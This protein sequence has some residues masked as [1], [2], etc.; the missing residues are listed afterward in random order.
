MATEVVNHLFSSLLNN[1][2]TPELLNIYHK[3]LDSHTYS[4]ALRQYIDT[5]I[6]DPQL[7]IWNVHHDHCF[8]SIDKKQ[9]QKITANF[10]DKGY[11]KEKLQKLH[12]RIN[13][14][15]ATSFVPQW[16]EDVRTLFEFDNIP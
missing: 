3:W 11:V 4:G 6:I 2:I 16:W 12:Q 13:S 7:N 10:R 5:Y 14:R 9:L 1:D 8:A 15:K